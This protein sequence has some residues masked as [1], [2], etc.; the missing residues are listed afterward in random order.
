[1]MSSHVAKIY[2]IL[3]VVYANICIKLKKNRAPTYRQRA[4]ATNEESHNLDFEHSLSRSA[5][6]EMADQPLR[7]LKRKVRMLQGH[8]AA[9]T[10]A[11]RM[12]I[13]QSAGSTS[14]VIMYF[15]HSAAYTFEVRM[16]G[17]HSAETRL[18]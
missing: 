3:D 7:G 2:P 8:S 13:G 9:H 11:A 6:S 12:T 15:G 5:P 10:I 17:G 16:R 14:G 1:M 4:T 18:G